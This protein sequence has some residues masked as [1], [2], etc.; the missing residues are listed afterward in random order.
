MVNFLEGTIVKA[1]IPLSSF[2]S[3][4]SFLQ[5]VASYGVEVRSYTGII[6][7][8]IVS[9]PSIIMNFFQGYA[10]AALDVG[11]DANYLLPEECLQA[12]LRAGTA[13]Q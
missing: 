12:A 3:H 2:S 4:L 8:R 5:K 6:S 11:A 1:L 7:V 10:K 13:F 9:H